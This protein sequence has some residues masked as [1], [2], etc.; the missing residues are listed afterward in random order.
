M[1]IESVLQVHGCFGHRSPCPSSSFTCRTPTAA[2]VG[3][4]IVSLPALSA[5]A[6]A[7]AP[8]RTD[9]L[10]GAVAAV[11]TPP[12]RHTYAVLLRAGVLIVD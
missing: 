3:A 7:L 8:S 1:R 5:F 12:L 4:V 6:S 9:P 10:T 11:L 2:I